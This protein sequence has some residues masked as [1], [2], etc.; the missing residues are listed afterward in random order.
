VGRK[1]FPVEAEL[2]DEFFVERRLDRRDGDELAIKGLVGVVEMGRTGQQAGAGRVVEHAHGLETAKHRH[3]RGRAV[4]HRGVHDLSLPRP[5][6]LQQS[7]DHAERKQQPA[8][9]E[10]ADQVQRRHRLASL[11]ADAVQRAGKGDVVQV[12]SRGARQRALLAPAG[13][14]AVD[15]PGIALHAGR[16]A[17]A[18][19]LRDARAECLEQ[20]V[21]AFRELQQSLDA[22]VLPEIERDGLAAAGERIGQGAAESRGSGMRSMR[23]T[24]APMSA[25][26][27]PQ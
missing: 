6:A 25:S 21:G 19:P 4:E 12:V 1:A 10:V 23:M 7:A 11:H 5:F 24:R 27:I 20:R 16:W 13:H 14:A 9:A 17:E 8:A 18:E 22:G 2:V 15:Q 3:H 26:I